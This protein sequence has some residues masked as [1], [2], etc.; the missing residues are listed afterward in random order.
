MKKKRPKLVYGHYQ[1]PEVWIERVRASEDPDN[2][3]LTKV[4]TADSYWRSIFVRVDDHEE[5][6]RLKRENPHYN[7]RWIPQQYVR[8]HP[9]GTPTRK[10]QSTGSILWAF[11][12]YP[13]ARYL[14]VNGQELIFINCTG[15]DLCAERAKAT[16]FDKLSYNHADY[17]PTMV[18]NSLMLCTDVPGN[19]EQFEI[20]Y[21]HRMHSCIDTKSWRRDKQDQISVVQTLC[22]NIAMERRKIMDAYNITPIDD[23]FE[24]VRDEVLEIVKTKEVVKRL[25]A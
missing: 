23:M 1:C 20:M 13:V 2:D 19:W 15:G 22:D 11:E 24:R 5:A 17:V 9:L 3:P 25:A 21:G 16:V 14:R 6:A 18:D 10:L 8:E 4:K 12:T 7:V